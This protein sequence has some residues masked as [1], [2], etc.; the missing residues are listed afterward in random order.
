MVGR[1]LPERVT[2][3]QNL[4]ETVLRVERL[5]REGVF[6]D[7]SFEVRAGEIVALAGLVGAGR[8]EVARAIFGV[9]SLRRR[10]G[11]GRRAR[12][13][14]RSSPSAAM[15]AGV[16]LVPEDR[17]QQGLVMSS[18]IMRNIALAS[19]RRLSHLGSDLERGR[20]PVRDRLGAQAP[21]QVRPP[22][23]PRQLALRRQ[24]AEGRAR[25]VA[26]APAVAAHRR[27]ADPRHRRRHQGRGAPAARR[28]GRRR[29]R[30]LDDLVG[31][32]RGAPPRRP[33]SRDARGPARRRVR[34]HRGVRGDDRRGRDAA[35]RTRWPHDRPT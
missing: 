21:D 25:E 34:P 31:A 9:D 14:R 4:G 24:P 19:L 7:I 16:G 17:R 27:R 10:L 5:C 23:E 15:G 1:D 11:D 3:D 12:R 18:S 6:L 8:S 28:A 29:G 2:T 33:R 35:R 30:D 13:L 32:A 26:G 22:L 20:A